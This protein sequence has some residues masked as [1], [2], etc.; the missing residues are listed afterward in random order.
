MFGIFSNTAALSPMKST[1]IKNLKKTP[2]FSSA[3]RSNTSYPYLQLGYCSHGMQLHDSLF[4][5]SIDF[6]CFKIPCFFCAC[7]F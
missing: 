5:K 4:K 3:E 1:E 6:I 7:A 2:I